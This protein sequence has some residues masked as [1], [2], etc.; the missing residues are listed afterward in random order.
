MQQNPQVGGRQVGPAKRRRYHVF[1][2]CNGN[3]KPRTCGWTGSLCGWKHA[4]APRVA[5][6][7]D[8]ERATR[9]VLTSGYRDWAGDHRYVL[10]GENKGVRGDGGGGRW[11]GKRRSIRRLTS[12]PSSH[13]LQPTL[14]AI[15]S[16]GA[17]PRPRGVYDYMMGGRRSSRLPFFWGG[18]T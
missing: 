18:G 1:L 10:V 4:W 9:T 8:D 12:P 6:V 16:C 17:I 3:L 15:P 11:G 5:S 7:F 14:F 13:F 2:G